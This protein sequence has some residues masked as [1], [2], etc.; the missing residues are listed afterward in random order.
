MLQEK[1]NSLIE[2]YATAEK[3]SVC[4]HVC[5]CV[6]EADIMSIIF[7]YILFG[8]SLEFEKAREQLLLLRFCMDSNHSRTIVFDFLL[9]HEQEMVS[10][11]PLHFVPLRKQVILRCL[12][13]FVLINTVYSNFEVEPI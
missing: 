9:P 11:V 2:N 1:D 4:M 13:I 5:E 7:H 3:L 12:Y 8:Q 6:N 10:L